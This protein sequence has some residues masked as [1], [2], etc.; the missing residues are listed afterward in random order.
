MAVD[1]QGLSQK[2]SGDF[3]DYRV[4]KWFTEDSY[5]PAKIRIR[6]W[7]RYLYWGN[8]WLWL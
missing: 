4:Y 1:E 5:I 2:M 6:A 8:I 3:E 7:L